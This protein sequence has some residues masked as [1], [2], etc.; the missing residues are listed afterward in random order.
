MGNTTGTTVMAHLKI[1]EKMDLFPY[2]LLRIPFCIHI[3]FYDLLITGILLI[4]TGKFVTV[5]VISRGEKNNFYKI[6][7]VLHISF[8]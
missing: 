6:Y 7:A 2:L 3:T 8:Y 4:R 1:E 5:L